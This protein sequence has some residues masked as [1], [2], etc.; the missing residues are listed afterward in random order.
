MQPIILDIADQQLRVFDSGTFVSAQPG[1]ARF[2]D[3]GVISV[4][5]AALQDA[6]RHPRQSSN[7]H[8]YRLSAETLPSAQL[9]RADLVSAQLRDLLA[10]DSRAGR[11]VVVVVP[12]YMRTDAL[13]LLLGILSANDLVAIA[14]VDAAVA[15]TRSQYIDQ[16]LIN[17][18]LS[19]HCATITRLDQTPT[20]T[21]VTDKRSLEHSGLVALNEAWL[22]FFAQAFVQQCRFDPL[23]SA[24]SEQAIADAMPAWLELLGKQ[25]RAELTIVHGGQ[26]HS[27]DLSRVDL[28][29]V[30]AGF[31]QNISDTVRTVLADGQ[32]P[33]LQMQA[34]VAALPG[35]SDYLLARV[36]GHYFVIDDDAATTALYARL[37]SVDNAADRLQLSLPTDAKVSL[38]EVAPKRDIERAVPS[39]LVVDARAI[40]LGDQPLYVGAVKHASNAPTVVLDGQPPGVSALHCELRM[41]AL[42]CELTDHSRYGTFLNGNRVNGNAVLQAGDVLRVGTPGIEFQLVR[43]EQH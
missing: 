39:H 4:G 27:I 3:S 18:D 8:W 7:D 22:K 41:N 36:G 10:G 16:T 31:Y 30:V 33:A 14:L 6:R 12:G 29:N 1:Y 11:Q 24:A 9:S 17:L 15:A 21:T 35:L 38:P 40:R 5:L 19:L 28:I 32:A 25:E 2:D 13:S 23:H 26:S 34:S 43:E 37:D 20:Q 42:Q